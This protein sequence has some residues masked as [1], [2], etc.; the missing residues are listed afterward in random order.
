VRAL[1]SGARSQLT[2]YCGDQRAWPEDLMNYV[3]A[4]DYCLQHRRVCGYCRS[5]RVRPGKRGNKTDAFMETLVVELSTMDRVSL[6]Q[7]HRGEMKQGWQEKLA[8]VAHA[9]SSAPVS[10]VCDGASSRSRLNLRPRPACHRPGNRVPQ[11]PRK[12]HWGARQ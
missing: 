2:D 11:W 5:S 8:H 6:S 3:S 10:G 7:D 4:Q 12:G 9:T 1:R